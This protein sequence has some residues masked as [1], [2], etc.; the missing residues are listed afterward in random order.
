M[1]LFCWSFGVE[2][3]RFQL[4]LH[5]RIRWG[6]FGLVDG[7]RG[8]HFSIQCD[9]IYANR[10]DK[11]VLKWFVTVLYRFCEY[12]TPGTE[13]FSEANLNAGEGQVADFSLAP[14]LSMRNDASDILDCGLKM[15]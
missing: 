13:I 4:N 11:T 15:E 3:E 14:R 1:L 7:F 10:K 9:T 6:S 5:D 2:Q 8:F 12:Y